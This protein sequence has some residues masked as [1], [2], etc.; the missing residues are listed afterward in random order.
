MKV[1]IRPAKEGNGFWLVADLAMGLCHDWFQTEAQAID[2]ALCFYGVDLS[3]KPKA[4]KPTTHAKVVEYGTTT[5]TCGC[6]DYQIRG[7]S[8]TVAGRKVCKHIQAVLD[9]AL[10]I[11]ISLK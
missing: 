5:N 2:F 11:K 10:A 8:Y 3:P 4:V 6:P 7:G 9:T 1:T